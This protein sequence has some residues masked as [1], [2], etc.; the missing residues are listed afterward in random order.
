MK[1]MRIVLNI[2]LA[3]GAMALSVPMA[4]AQQQE[5][6]QSGQPV[7][8]S[9]PIPAYHSPLASAANNEQD[10]ATADS[11][12]LLPDTTA[13][14]GIQDLSLGVPA[15][16]HSYWQPHVDLS[17]T[18]DSNPLTAQGTDR[19]DNLHVDLWRSGFAP[20]FRKFDADAEL[21]RRRFIF[22]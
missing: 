14:T 18:V 15:T 9:Q 6:D 8:P 21:C 22:E 7:Q 5:P 11:Q 3:I 20:K 10:Q 2:C 13:L 1:T 12:K 17:S 16:N 19:M 4:C